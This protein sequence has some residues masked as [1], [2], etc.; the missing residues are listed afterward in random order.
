MEARK[1]LT[2]KEIEALCLAALKTRPGLMDIQYVKIH[3]Y[4]GPRSWTWELEE[5][6][7]DAGELALKDAMSEIN[8]LQG[9]FDLVA[10]RARAAVVRPALSKPPT[11]GQSDKA[12]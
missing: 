1:R 8:K 11:L 6:G 4:L 12:T 2:A 5:V 7:P 3:H 10:D 9:M